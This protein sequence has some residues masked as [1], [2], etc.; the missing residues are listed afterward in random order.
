MKL[1]KMPLTLF[2][3]GLLSANLV[4]LSFGLLPTVQ[5][6]PKKVLVVTTS[7]GFRHSSI[8]TAEKMLN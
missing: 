1:M 2:S 5:A 6:A 4:L 3:S 8:P 7:T